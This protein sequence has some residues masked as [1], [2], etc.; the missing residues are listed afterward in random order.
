M[1]AVPLG[2]HNSVEDRND[3]RTASD[4]LPALGIDDRTNRTCKPAIQQRARPTVNAVS[5]SG[6]SILVINSGS[7]SVKFALFA[8][9]QK[10]PRLFSGAMERIGLAHGHFHTE[11]PTGKRVI[12]DQVSLPS[13]RDALELLLKTLKD[14]LPTPRLFAVGHRV[15]HGGADHDCPLRVTRELEDR[16]R[17][18]IPLAPLHQPHNLAGISAI[19]ELDQH[20]FQVACFDTAFHHNLPRLAR[21][22]GLPRAL[23]DGGI[24]RYGFHGLSYEYVVETLRKQNVQVEKERIVIAHLG[25]GASMCALR[26]GVSVET[27]MGFSTLAGLMMG[28]RS[29]DLDPGAV[30]YLMTEM[31]MDAG[32]VQNLLYKQSGLLG[33]SGIS[34]DMRDLLNCRDEPA[35]EAVAL[36]CYRARHHLAALTA[37]LDG[38]DRLVFT[39]GIGAYSSEIR[40][41]I[42]HGFAYLGLRLDSTA[43]Q[44]NA[45]TISAHGAPVT[46]QALVSDEEYM[47]ARHVVQLSSSPGKRR[48]ASCS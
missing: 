5:L 41:R 10:L 21:L 33:V 22:T 48:E 1:S 4:R 17:R 23:Q 24:R 32:A 36:F 44:S 35:Q 34:S 26:N 42:C 11:D 19:R 16:L 45:G 25:S 27:T 31:G 6:T 38:I 7:S 20:L 18:L 14:Q 29:G 2:H 37:S 28:T 15:A 40:E 12:D 30:L 46:V 43:S 3:K 9:E 8:A 47:I 13:H 39:G